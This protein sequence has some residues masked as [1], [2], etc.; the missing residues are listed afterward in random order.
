MTQ[1]V[2]FVRVAGAAFCIAKYPV[3]VEEY[4][5]FLASGG[6]QEPP[7]WAEQIAHPKR[8]VVYV[9]WDDATAYAKWCD[10]RLPTSDEWKAASTIGRRRYPWGNDT[11]TKEHANYG[12]SV[13]HPTDVDAYP[14]GAT[15]DGVF[16]LAGNVWE[17]TATEDADGRKIVRGGS[18][19]DD[20]SWLWAA[21]QGGYAP[22]IRGDYLGFRLCRDAAE[23]APQA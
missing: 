22:V 15:P 14:L 1:T 17:W 3:T 16:D 23:H 13:G 10:A 18:Y 12:M 4:G 5:E 11:P 7:N 2:D 21:A 6:R 20:A 9:T 19:L 8:P